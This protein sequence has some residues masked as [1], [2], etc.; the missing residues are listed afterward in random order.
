MSY[1]QGKNYKGK[2]AVLDS[3]NMKGEPKRRRKK[4]PVSAVHES[5]APLQAGLRK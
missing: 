1:R 4:I 5:L 3:K 2:R